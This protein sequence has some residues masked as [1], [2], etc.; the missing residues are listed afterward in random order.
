MTARILR[1]I[2]TCPAIRRELKDMHLQAMIS[3][4]LVAIETVEG[5]YYIRID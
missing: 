4:F 3:T 1:I 5:Y 2:F